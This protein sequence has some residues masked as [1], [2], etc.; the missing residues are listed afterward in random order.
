MNSLEQCRC[1]IRGFFLI[2]HRDKNGK[3]LGIYRVPNGIVD[4]GAN[5]LLET[6]FHAG[7]Q[8]TTWYIG[9]VDNAGYTGWAVGDT[10]SSHAGWTEATGY[11]GANRP[12]WTCGAAASRQITNATT[13]D[14]AITG[15]ATLKGI[16]ITTGQVKGATTGTLW[17]V[18]L[19]SSTVAVNNGD[20]LKV[21]YT[22][23]VP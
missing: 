1:S 22:I 5:H 21:T 3:L 15:S 9:L 6:E 10:M 12:Q 23:S 2:E 17:S 11:S 20:T 8:A 18:A 16:F 13:V 19:F 4:V 7:S 14:F